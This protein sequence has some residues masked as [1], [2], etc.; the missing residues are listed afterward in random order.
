MNNGTVTGKLVPKTL[1]LGP[2]FS[3]KILVPGPDLS[4][5]SGPS[6]KLLVPFKLQY[7]LDLNAATD[8]S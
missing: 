2:I 3:A 1:V 8:V 7:E 5:K 6:L 4:K